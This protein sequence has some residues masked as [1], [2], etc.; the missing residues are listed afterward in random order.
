MSGYRPHVLV[1]LIMIPVAL[2]IGPP[3]IRLVAG[4]YGNSKLGISTPYT[5]QFHPGE[6]M[7]ISVDGDATIGV[8]SCSLVEVK[9]N[10]Q[11]LSLTHSKSQLLNSC[12]VGAIPAD[13]FEA[14]TTV[15]QNTEVGFVSG[16]GT[17][18]VSSPGQTTLSIDVTGGAVYKTMWWVFMAAGY[19]VLCVLGSLAVSE[20][21]I[22]RA[23]RS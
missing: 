8:G 6:V 2:L 22:V 16:E 23:A 10:D 19:V 14:F 20:I 4:S 9:V 3:M 1:W 18:A 21:K 11:L 7:S 17:I 12:T 5:Y 13:Y 15:T